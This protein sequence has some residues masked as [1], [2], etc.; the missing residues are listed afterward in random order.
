[1]I[2]Q[3]LAD[4]HQRAAAGEMPVLVVDDLEAV[5][6]EED[7]AE[8]PLRAARAVNLRFQNADEPAVIRKSRER[9]G[10]RHGPHLLEKPRLLQQSAGEHGHVTEGLAPLREKKW[11]VKELP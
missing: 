2:A 1:M 8:G 11:A 5:H 7:N 6:V 9:I 4:A 10:D 3:N